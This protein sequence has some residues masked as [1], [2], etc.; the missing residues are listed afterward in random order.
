MRAHKN[1][2]VL[3]RVAAEEYSGFVIASGIHVGRNKRL[4]F[5]KDLFSLKT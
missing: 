1:V 3:K 5:D 2:D 4:K